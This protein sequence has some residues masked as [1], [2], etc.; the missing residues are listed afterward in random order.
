MSAGAVRPETRPWHNPRP[1][2]TASLQ[3]QLPQLLPALADGSLSDLG[4]GWDFCTYQLQHPHQGTWVLRVPKRA[5]EASRL[6]RELELL[7]KLQPLR[8]Q[9]IQIPVYQWQQLDP[10][11]G[12]VFAAYPW[13]PGQQ[14]HR[15]AYSQALATQLGQQLG[16]WLKALHQCQPLPPPRQI[17]DQ[18]SAN[19]VEF[20]QMLT[21]V[22]SA[23]P[24]PLKQPLQQLLSQRHGSCL[25]PLPAQGGGQLPGKVFCHMDLGT[26]HILVN[27]NRISAV[28]DW[29]DADWDHPLAD[30][31][32]LWSWGGDAAADAAFTAYGAAPNPRNWFELRLRG[33]CYL[34]G[35]FHYGHL[36]AQAALAD[37]GLAGLERL[38]AMGVLA[39]P[40]TAAVFT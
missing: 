14:L 15:Q 35:Q 39:D 12:L 32:G 8:Q 31:V 5:N 29:T 30:F 26:E 7:A 27:T 40:S 3:Q 24:V 19:L 33:I 25:S 18:F 28:I 21:E 11:Q 36:G 4:E 17:P 20:R 34:L 16:T 23:L 9:Q 37:F 13:L 38:L 1:I 2:S 22:A 6:K 10:A